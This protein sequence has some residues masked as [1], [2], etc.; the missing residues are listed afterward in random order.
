MLGERCLA[1]QSSPDDDLYQRYKTLIRILHT[2]FQE[3]NNILKGV[4]D[5]AK[6]TITVGSVILGVIIAGTR[7]LSGLLAE[8][9]TRSE[10]MSQES[11]IHGVSVSSLMGWGI[12]M[13]IVSIVVSFVAMGVVRIKNPFGSQVLLTGDELD[14]NKVKM[15]KTSL[16]KDVYEATCKAYA[17]ATYSRERASMV[18]GAVTLAG[19]ICLGVGLVMTSIAAIG[20][21]GA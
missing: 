13:I 17:R 21:F 20:L 8:N 14:Q 16:K 2:G 12:V 10:V 5:K 7:V 4:Y 19:Q 6:T 9:S 18:S 3:S 1:P 15:W 11:L